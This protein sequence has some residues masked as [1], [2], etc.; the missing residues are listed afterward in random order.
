MANQLTG[1]FDAALQISV[2]RLNGLLATM[3]QNRWEREQNPI[4][5]LPTFPH[6]DRI[7][8]GP[9]PFGID[10]HLLRLATQVHHRQMEQTGKGPGIGLPSIS[11]MVESLPPEIAAVARENF[12]NWENITSLAADSPSIARGLAEV[13]ISAPFVILANGDFNKVTVHVFV[14]ARYLADTPSFLLPE[15]IHGE[16]RIGY[17]MKREGN[18]LKIVPPE[19]DSKVSFISNTTLPYVVTAAIT[20]EVFL[21][22]RERFRPNLVD[23][24][25]DFGFAGSFK[26]IGSGTG[27]VLAMPVSLTGGVPAGGVDSL[28]QAWLGN[29][30]FALAV[31]KEFVGN[32]FEPALAPIRG[33][34]V[35]IT[36]NVDALIFGFS[37]AEFTLRILDARLEWSAGLVT[38]KIDAKLLA[39]V[40]FGTIRESYDIVVTQGMRFQQAPRTITL[41]A[42]D[43]DLKVT[44]AP[45]EFGIPDA[46]W[47][48]A[49][50]ARNRALPAVQQMVPKIFQ[51]A[52][53]PEI[54][55][56]ALL[57]I[58]V[59]LR[60]FDPN[61]AVEYKELEVNTSGLIV[62]G[63]ISGGKRMDPIAD[64]R[65]ADGGDSYTALHSWIPGGR[66]E[67]LVWGMWEKVPFKKALAASGLLWT[68]PW[69]G[70]PR[71]SGEETEHFMFPHAWTL[72]HS[73]TVCLTIYGSRRNLKGV[74]ED[75]DE[76]WGADNTRGQCA[77]VVL[78]PIFI[79]HNWKE[80]EIVNIWPDFT[81]E[82][83]IEDLVFAH[84]DAVAQDWPAGELTTN[85]LVH[86]M[87]WNAE[88]PM[89]AIHEALALMKKKQFAL[90][91]VIVVPPGSLKVHR[92]EMEAKLG[93]DGPHEKVGKKEGQSPVHIQIA[94]DLNRG[95]S[96]MLHASG[97]PA[98]F[99]VNARQEIAWSVDGDVDPGELAAVLDK[100][101]VP[102]PAAKGRLPEPAIRPGNLL[103]P[104]N[105]IDDQGSFIRLQDFSEKELML[106]F[107]KST[108][109]P[110][111]RELQRLQEIQKTDDN[112][113]IVG[114]CADEDPEVI[115]RIRDQYQLS[116]ILAQDPERQ[117]ARS[118][119]VRC[120]PTTMRIGREGILHS[121]QFGYPMKQGLGKE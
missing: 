45:D 29:R 38:L 62:R 70:L 21:L 8:L 97:A 74:V 33:F 109:R 34:S 58:G 113:I 93:L 31:S 46:A 81:G 71:F 75:G 2:Q 94:E 67:K 1:V 40:V 107:W 41:T 57:R 90:T 98:T 48:A 66:I 30:D 25:S 77:P 27:Q 72:P 73:T 56:G 115:S 65:S 85:H 86:F 110:C 105:F 104:I 5:K 88:Q 13:Q 89:Q 118:L 10:P 44:G 28:K 7:R 99:F 76:I 50:D 37:V 3:H 12:P 120:W 61:L 78:P 106:C 60:R 100:E 4:S 117:I 55:K 59:A 96:E 6:T 82:L 112:L 16:V 11:S 17:E 114:L 52:E 64:I 19:D 79:R 15:R 63:I 68:L 111:V 83:I 47:K 35:R 121:T 9:P 18:S 20:K 87:D 43:S 23:F 91:L 36:V 80:F 103:P 116:F 26:A 119:T 101:I 84:I 22:V 108:S 32:Q 69:E 49:R 95:W 92:T 51:N 53:S 42:V 14:R 39:S 24:T 102:A 54:G